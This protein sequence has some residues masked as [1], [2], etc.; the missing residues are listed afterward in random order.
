[1][2]LVATEVEGAQ[3]IPALGVRDGCETSCEC[4]ELSPAPLHCSNYSLNQWAAVCHSSC[5]ADILW[6]MCHTH[7]KKNQQEQE[8][9]SLS[10]FMLFR[11]YILS[12]L[13][14]MRLAQLLLHLIRGTLRLNSYFCLPTNFLLPCLPQSH[15]NGRYEENIQM[16]DNVLLNQAEIA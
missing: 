7:T 14:W 8:Q 15:R 13:K 12:F 10:W 16:T 5:W 3:K 1:M 9:L 4:W 6:H 11:V 2:C